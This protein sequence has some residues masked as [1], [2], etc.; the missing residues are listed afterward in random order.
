VGDTAK[1]GPAYCSV[2]RTPT[3]GHGIVSALDAA[4]FRGVR[5]PSKPA[6]RRRAGVAQRTTKDERRVDDRKRRAVEKQ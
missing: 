4:A 6:K 5:A 1:P 2:A 3:L